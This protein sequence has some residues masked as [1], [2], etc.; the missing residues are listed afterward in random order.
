MGR[1][2]YPVT[3]LIWARRQIA[4]MT[5]QP[6]DWEGLVRRGK[7]AGRGA[8]WKLA[9]EA[10]RWLEDWQKPQQAP[11]RRNL[12]IEEEYRVLYERQGGVCAICGEKPKSGRLVV[13]HVHGSDRVRG[14][15][16]NLCNPALG[17][18]KDDAAR[19]EAAI[20]FLKKSDTPRLGDAYRR[21]K[22]GEP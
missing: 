13:D 3:R 22:A 10:V 11:S 7:T 20:E 17:L 4:N 21:V 19:L 18:F 6:E 15:L 2:A 9:T 12:L 8:L 16:C 14:L 5:D 1:F